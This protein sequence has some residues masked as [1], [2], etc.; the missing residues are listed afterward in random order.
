MRE[1][2]PA[3]KKYIYESLRSEGL[4]D[5]E[6]TFETDK[7]FLTDYG[8]FSYRME[9]GYPFLT[10]FYVDK[11]KRSTRN[12]LSLYR[13]FKQQII[14]EGH[15]AFIAEVMNKKAYLEKFIKWLGRRKHYAEA[16]NSKYYLIGVS[17]GE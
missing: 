11:N 2:Q 4:S 10:H 5:N 9:H 13:L 15:K 17:K 1:Y 8:F 6:M 16:N 3:D 7:T 14:S 12:A